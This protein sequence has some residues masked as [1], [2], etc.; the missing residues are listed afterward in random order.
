M[1][2]PTCLKILFILKVFSFLVPVKP[3]NNIHFSNDASCE[4]EP[5]INKMSLISKFLLAKTLL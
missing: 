4:T 2:E 1:K 3:Q 5:L